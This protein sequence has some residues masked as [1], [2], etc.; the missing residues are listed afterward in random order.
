MS[1]A[2]GQL[3]G[4]GNRKP[5]NKWIGYADLMKGETEKLG[6]KFKPFDQ[7]MLMA[8]WAN[9]AVMTDVKKGVCRAL[10]A[11]YLCRQYAAACLKGPDGEIDA[12]ELQN[13][14]KECP[15][16]MLASQG[17]FFRVFRE[18][19]LS[20]DE[21]QRLQQG[22]P[23]QRSPRP[24]FESDNWVKPAGYRGHLALNTKGKWLEAKTVQGTP[25]R[26]L[27]E[28]WRVRRIEHLAEAHH[29][30]RFFSNTDKNSN[31]GT[32]T[33]DYPDEMKNTMS[34]IS[35]D[36]LVG[37]REGVINLQGPYGDWIWEMRGS[38]QGYFMC[39]VTDHALALAVHTFGWNGYTVKFFDPNYGECK[40][41]KLGDFKKFLGLIAE[42][43][44]I[45]Y[46]QMKMD[47]KMF[48]NP[49]EIYR[50]TLKE[51]TEALNK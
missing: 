31:S 51:L 8:A 41:K 10:S 15:P 24:E 22:T 42:G 6:G 44:R 48:V 45:Q 28:P 1:F 2:G 27:G 37:S 29:D 38:M 25:A 17:Q 26:N 39:W 12:A 13:F 32:V 49:N 19:R 36:G 9:L 30:T 34:L 40:F 46:H 21:Y 7:R 20:Q 14:W 35:G 16:L 47:Y 43:F 11:V 33:K 4:D 5:L 23:V 3:G 18:G 50:K